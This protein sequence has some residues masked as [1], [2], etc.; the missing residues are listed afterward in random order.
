MDYVRSKDI[1]ADPITKGLA[2]EILKETNK[3]IG[4]MPIYHQ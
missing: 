1:L 2:R 3:G 4:L